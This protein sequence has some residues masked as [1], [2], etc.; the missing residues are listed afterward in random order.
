MSFFLSI[1]FAITL[2]LGPIAMGQ[3]DDE[4]R[5]VPKNW[6]RQVER[7]I[8]NGNWHS[9]E[10][11][12]IQVIHSPEC[13]LQPIH[14]DLYI[15]LAEFFAW[16][17]EVDLKWA[18]FWIQKM[19]FQLQK[20]GGFVREVFVERL[21]ELWPVSHPIWLHRDEDGD[22]LLM[23][24]MHWAD[25][26]QHWVVILDLIDH[27]Q[28]DRSLYRSLLDAQNRNGDTLFMLAIQH[29]PLEVIQFLLAS[30]VEYLNLEARDINGRDAMA[31]MFRRK[32]SKLHLL[33][34]LYFPSTEMLAL[35]R[36]QEGIHMAPSTG[37]LIFGEPRLAQ[38]IDG[39]EQH[40]GRTVNAVARGSF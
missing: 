7:A 37:I 9:L 17:G 32:D 27:I 25:D 24:L 8:R 28:Q 13:P 18:F 12:L 10:R 22:F 36:Q 19:V 20:C 26:V 40:R 29:A 39:A 6:K 33:W 30:G 14:D 35:W 1:L 4:L 3:G 31:F 34:D 38:E 2:F 11:I 23:A 15:Q 5:G 16:Q 21:L